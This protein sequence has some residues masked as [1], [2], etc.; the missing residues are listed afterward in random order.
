MPLISRENGDYFGGVGE[1]GGDGGGEGED[2]AVLEEVWIF[3]GDDEI[4]DVDYVGFCVF[5]GGFDDFGIGCGCDLGVEKVQQLQNIRES[6]PAPEGQTN[7]VHTYKVND[8]RIPSDSY[9][10]VA[11]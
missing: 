7:V 6:A 9:H 4:V 8:C 10:G 11:R 2:E 3:G 1:D 5:A